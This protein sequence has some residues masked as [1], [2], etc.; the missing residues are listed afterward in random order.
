MT[1]RGE[2]ALLW[3]AGWLSAVDESRSKSVEVQRVWEICDDLLQFMAV[4]DALR[5]DDS[6]RRENVSGA[7]VLWSGAAEVLHC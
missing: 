5:L 2:C 1:P 4:P 6:V 7:W 3:P